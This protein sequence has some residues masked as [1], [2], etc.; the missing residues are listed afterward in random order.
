MKVQRTT[1]PWWALVVLCMALLVVSIETSILNI[2]LP[3]LTTD[4]AAS[5]SALAW[6][7]DSYLVAFAG[8]LFA[9]AA[10][11]ERFGRRGVMVLGL[12]VVAGASG[13]AAMAHDPG[14]LI[15]WRT[16]MGVGGALVMPATL[17]ILVNIF[18]DRKERTKA[19]AYWSLMNAVGSFI[20]PLAGGLLLRWA[21]WQ[22]CFLVVIPVAV[23]AMV[24]AYVLVP[25]SRDPSAARFDWV[26]AVLSTAALGGLV[27]AIIEGPARG[28]TDPYVLGGFV[29]ATI[30]GA[31]FIAWERRT[32]APML[33]LS[34][35]ASRQLRAASVAITIAFLAMMSA[36][37]LAGLALQLAKNYT[38]LA[39]AMALSVPITAVNFLIVPRT[40]W[41]VNRFGTRTLI[42]GGIAAIAASSLV[43]S[44][45]TLTSSYWVLCLGFA[46]MAVAF[47][48]FV[49]ASTEAIVTAVP[50][51]R[52]GGAS[53]VNQLTRQIGQALGIA[54]G[55]AIAAVGYSANYSSP[56][57]ASTEGE[58]HAASTSFFDALA[59]A[60]R[61]GAGKEA[62]R[63]AAQEAYVDG[64]RLALWIGAAVALAG[65]AYAWAALPDRRT[66]QDAALPHDAPTVEARGVIAEEAGA[67]EAGSPFPPGR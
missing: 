24:L 17:S 57:G 4:L 13:M 18:V 39:A 14:V 20:G 42:A 67:L 34:M 16:V 62:L 26:G 27:W 12:G 1:N 66:E 40:A 56:A 22:A 64:V 30:A 6:I 31:A 33:D 21:D 7:V 65:A 59:V 54:L 8:L 63:Q 61:A 51:E 38:P 10:L 50:P 25:T 55:A 44:T 45:V 11:A 52:S 2:A 32:P 41:L 60:D 43:I 28:W 5:E 37:Y 29:G 19:I 35:F 47:S 49:P 46:L 15:L 23:L 58:A 36:M 3:R 53:A 9:G 48:A